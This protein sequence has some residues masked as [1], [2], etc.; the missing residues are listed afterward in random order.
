MNV[1]QLLVSMLTALAFLPVPSAG[2]GKSPGGNEEEANV[3]DAEDAS[4]PVYV[5]GS[6]FIMAIVSVSTALFV[7]LLVMNIWLCISMMKD[8]KTH[9]GNQYSLAKRTDSDLDE[10]QQLNV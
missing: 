1:K 6:G 3:D 7:L 5:V 10:K 8:R 4:V 2:G 9:T